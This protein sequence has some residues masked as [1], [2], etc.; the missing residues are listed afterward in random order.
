MELDF[1][2]LS[3]QAKLKMMQIYLKK[4]YK[5]NNIFEIKQK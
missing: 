3:A 4:P 1:K 5:V 2:K